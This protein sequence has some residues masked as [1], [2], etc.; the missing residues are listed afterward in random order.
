ML[1][2]VDPRRDKDQDC[3]CDKHYKVH[4]VVV[5]DHVTGFNIF[6]QKWEKVVE[7]IIMFM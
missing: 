6:T 2:V 7:A 3:S 5:L 1:V 4:V